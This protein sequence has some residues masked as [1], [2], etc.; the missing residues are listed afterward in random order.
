M[1]RV[2]MPNRNSPTMKRCSRSMRIYGYASEYARVAGM[3]LR[4]AKSEPL[5]QT[6]SRDLEG[7]ELLN[8]A[9]TAERTN[10]RYKCNGGTALMRETQCKHH[11]D[12]D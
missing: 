8:I 9:E 6:L 3:S 10:V 5:F 4:L 2:D 12:K 11:S 1:V 7:R